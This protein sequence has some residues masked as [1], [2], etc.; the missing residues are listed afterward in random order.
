M[1]SGRFIM[2]N[3][4][5]RKGG[6]EGP[7]ARGMHDVTERVEAAGGISEANS[8]RRIRKDVPDG[9]R[10]GVAKVG[11]DAWEGKTLAMA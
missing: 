4:E 5:F 10:A 9:S 3:W 8:F 11:T 6:K 2:M 7:L 1:E